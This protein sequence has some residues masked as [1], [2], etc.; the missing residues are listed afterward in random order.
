MVKLMMSNE[1]KKANEESGM[2]WREIKKIYN[3][4]EEGGRLDAVIAKFP[5]MDTDEIFEIITVLSGGDVIG[6]DE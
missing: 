4:V 3:S 2:Q 5:D 6:E 1:E